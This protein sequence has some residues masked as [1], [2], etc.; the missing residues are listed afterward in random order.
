MHLTC[1][2]AVQ[3]VDAAVRN[4]DRYYRLTA[5]TVSGRLDESERM[6]RAFKV[7]RLVQRSILPLPFSCTAPCC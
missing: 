5:V 6:A 1:Q 7:R 3:A 4:A 2:G